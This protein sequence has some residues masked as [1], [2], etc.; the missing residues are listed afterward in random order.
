MAD[1][2]D[3]LRTCSGAIN[4]PHC[5]FKQ[6]NSEYILKCDYLQGQ[7]DCLNQTRTPTSII[8]TYEHKK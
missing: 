7:D 2:T 4:S 3:I 1:L 8:F 5:K 6:T